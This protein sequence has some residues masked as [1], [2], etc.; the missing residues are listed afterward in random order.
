MD[1]HVHLGPDHFRV[2]ASPSVDPALDP[3]P[4][5][6][7]DPGATRLEVEGGEGEEAS[8]TEIPVVLGRAEGNPVR[9]ARLGE[10]SLALLPRRMGKG[11]W[12]IEVEGRRYEAQVNDRGQEAAL[13]ALAA[14]G[15]TAG[16]APLR[17]PM[18]GLVVRV[19]VEVGQVVEPGEGVVIV[20]AMKME[21]E[22]RAPARA[23]VT[24][25]PVEAG[26]AVEKDTVLVEFGPVEEEG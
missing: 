12:E 8:R 6:L 15:A 21:N 2:R 7:P 22:L 5:A 26:M 17:A 16:I 23:R 9:G 24:G 20:E 19:E 11:L 3:L 10:R 13:Q 14:R 1:F 4:E 25:L 18:P